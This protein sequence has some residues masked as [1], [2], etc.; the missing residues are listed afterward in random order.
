MVAIP[1]KAGA[2]APYSCLP[3]GREGGV[4]VLPFLTGFTLFVIPGL[5]KPAPYLLRGNPVFLNWIPAGVYPGENWD[6]N[7]GFGNNVKKC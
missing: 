5:T 1:A 2:S 4:K 6:G 7:D 3:A